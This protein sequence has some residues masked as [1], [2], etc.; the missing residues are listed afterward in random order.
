MYY[1]ENPSPSL[2]ATMG[3]SNGPPLPSPIP[4]SVFLQHLSTRPQALG[5]LSGKIP[6]HPA[7]SHISSQS[8][9]VEGHLLPHGQKY[10]PVR[11]NCSESPLGRVQ[12][13]GRVG[14]KESR[15]R[16]P[17]QPPS[18]DSPE[19]GGTV[20]GAERRPTQHGKSASKRVSPTIQFYLISRNNMLST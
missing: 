7:P 14:V 5:H 8:S 12:G 20:V 16:D 3:S 10:L 2:G 18:E 1:S 13:W 15:K 19:W 11:S 17:P 6:S 9:W 4:V